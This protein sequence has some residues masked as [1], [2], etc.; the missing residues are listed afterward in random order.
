MRRREG[1]DPALVGLLL[2]GGSRGA[3]DYTEDL[4]LQLEA[5]GHLV[6]RLDPK[7]GRGSSPVAFVAMPFGERKDPTRGLRRYDSDAT[8]NRLLLPALLDAATERYAQTSRPA[9]R[10]LTAVWWLF[11]MKRGRASSTRRSTWV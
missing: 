10:S 1:D 11:V 9:A 8:W 6:L 7:V 5:A 4:G 3:N 2:S